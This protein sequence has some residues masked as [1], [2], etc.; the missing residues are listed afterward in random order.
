MDAEDIQYFLDDL[1]KTI[2]KGSLT[3]G[4]NQNDYIKLL[5][6]KMK[7]TYNAKKIYGWDTKL[8][9]H[10]QIEYDFVYYDQGQKWHVTETEYYVNIYTDGT[11]K[12]FEQ[13][14]PTDWESYKIFLTSLIK[15]RLFFTNSQNRQTARAELFKDELTCH[16]LRKRFINDV[17]DE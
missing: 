15:N 10:I 9:G 6:R 3:K 7:W 16:F 1:Q 13:P 11:F 17:F 12:I 14:M 4:I 5:K 2:Y 8:L